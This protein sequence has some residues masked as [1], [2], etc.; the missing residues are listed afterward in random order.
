[1][2]RLT[3]YGGLNEIGGNKILIEDEDTRIFLDFG[4]SFSKK[5]KYYD[6]PFLAPRSEKGLLELG[7]LPNIRGIYEFDDAP[8]TIDAVFL[9][10]SHMDHS[11]YISLIDR[12]I[13]VYCGETTR[14]ILNAMNA[15]RI[16]NFETD[17]SGIE[18]K[19]FRSGKK[20]RVKNLEVETCHVDHSVPASY[21]FIVY[22][23]SGTI[24]YTG[25]YRLRG[26]RPELTKDFIQRLEEVKPDIFITEATN[27]VGAEVSSEREVR[28][29][30][31]RIVK[32]TP[33]LVLASFAS[34]D[35]DRLRT[36][37][38]VAKSN[39]RVL[40]VSLKQAY[41]L[42]ELK[43]DKRLDI[44]DV[45]SD[46]NI[47]AYKK[48]KNTFYNWEKELMSRLEVKDSSQIRGMQ[49][50]VIL[51]M[52]FWDF[53]ELIDIVPEKGSCYIL[54]SSEPFNEEQ[55]IEF[56]KMMN[57]LDHFGLPEYHVH[58][59]GHIMPHELRWVINKIRPKV[60]IPVHT[61]RPWMFKKFIQENVLIPR[62]GKTV[63]I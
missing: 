60:T 32:H 7:I 2:T 62:Y 46:E 55:E 9:T 26:T 19:T 40:A 50:R 8:P 56:E 1:M 51:V 43:R 18:F 54:S 4:M 61:E 49:D 27:I 24:A 42:Y 5:R 21:G 33:K 6:E 38:E 45:S 12:H 53:Q 13:P 23:S 28:Y 25:D 20:I 63:N 34:A 16:R 59:S 57:W 44:P 30:L 47:V 17:I 22:T 37:Y 15:V 11:A 3:F 41:L 52:S 29:K 31:N 48:G 58:V 14:I 36:F 35:I 10:H 39:E